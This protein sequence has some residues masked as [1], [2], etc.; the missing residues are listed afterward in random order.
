MTQEKNFHNNA[1]FK[2]L[3]LLRHYLIQNKVH[4]LLRSL[5]KKLQI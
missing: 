3:K 1:L 5:W 2:D 4:N